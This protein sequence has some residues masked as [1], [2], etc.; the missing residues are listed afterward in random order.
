MFFCFCVSVSV[1]GCVIVRA[2]MCVPASVITDL[3][4]NVCVCESVY[5]ELNEYMQYML[6]TL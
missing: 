5:V 2:C 3:K 4:K 6:I 1:S